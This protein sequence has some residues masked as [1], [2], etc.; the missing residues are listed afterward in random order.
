M[1][2]FTDNADTTAHNR[3]SDD[4]DEKPEKAIN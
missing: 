3:F 1:T 4:A 2:T